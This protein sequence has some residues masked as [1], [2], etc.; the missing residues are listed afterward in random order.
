MPFSPTREKDGHWQIEVIW[1][2]RES[3]VNWG[4]DLTRVVFR[5]KITSDLIELTIWHP[6][7]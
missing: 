6:E 3:K 1:R 2:S 5:V 7:Y 4:G